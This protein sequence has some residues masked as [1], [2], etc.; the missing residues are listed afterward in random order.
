MFVALVALVVGL[1]RQQR[2]PAQRRALAALTALQ[3]LTGLSNVILD[4]PLAAAV[5]HT[6]GAA[7]M[8]TVLVWALCASRADAL[9]P[10]GNAR[11]AG[12]TP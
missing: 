6:G 2:L 9:A 7:A 11:P 10:A 5:V 8:M 12:V 4:W 1:W 3:L